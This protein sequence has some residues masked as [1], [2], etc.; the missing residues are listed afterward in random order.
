MT[1]REARS[2]IEAVSIHNDRL[3]ALDCVKRS[4]GI[5]FLAL[6][7]FGV[8]REFFFNLKFMFNNIIYFNLLLKRHIKFTLREKNSR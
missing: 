5:E 3:I 8:E 6:H 4:V 1:C 7:C 2:I